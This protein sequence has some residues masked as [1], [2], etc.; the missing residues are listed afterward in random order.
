MRSGRNRQRMKRVVKVELTE[1]EAWALIEACA[2]RE[3]GDTSDL[4]TRQFKAL[5]RAFIKLQE[6]R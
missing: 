4:T 1:S 2:F 5:M 6:A 3:A